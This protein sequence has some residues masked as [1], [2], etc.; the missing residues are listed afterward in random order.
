MGK[1]SSMC[2]ALEHEP[3]LQTLVD[4]LSSVLGADA[5]YK[6]AARDFLEYEQEKIRDYKEVLEKLRQ[7]IPTISP[8]ANLLE[9]SHPQTPDEIKV[10]TQQHFK[11]EVGLSKKEIS[12][13]QRSGIINRTKKANGK[14]GTSFYV[15]F[16]AIRP[17]VFTWEIQDAKRIQ[18]KEGITNQINK[19][20]GNEA[21]FRKNLK[22]AQSQSAKIK[23]ETLFTHVDRF[24][25]RIIQALRRN[26][27]IKGDYV[28]RAES[29][30]LG[31]GRV[32][33]SIQEL[34][35]LYLIHR[36]PLIE[37]LHYVFLKDGVIVGTNASTAG[38]VNATGAFDLDLFEKNYKSL[39][40]DAVYILHNHPSG[41][42]LPSKADIDM[43]AEIT[44]LSEGINFKGQLII[45]TDKFTFIP[46]NP[47]VD[48]K[49]YQELDYL[50]QPKRL[51][52]TR[53]SLGGTF[54]QVTESLKQVG[55]LLLKNENI[56][57]VIYISTYG[58]IVG[59]DSFTDEDVD[60]IDFTKRMREIGAYNY[61][62]FSPSKESSYK[63]EK[64][65]T[66]YSE[67]AAFYMDSGNLRATPGFEYNI[68]ETEKTLEPNQMRMWEGL[69]EGRGE[70]ENTQDSEPMYYR[71][72]TEELSLENS[73][74]NRALEILTKLAAQVGVE[75]VP[76]TEAEATEL[77]KNT[78][79]PYNGEPAFF[80]AGQV[81]YIPSKLTTKIALHEFSHPL[82]RSISVDNHNLFDKLFTDLLSTPEGVE[83]V[84]SVRQR[85]PELEEGSDRFKEEV[86]VHAL[87]TATQR[88]L[89]SLAEPKGFAKVI[90]DILV[91]F[92]QLLRKIFKVDVSKLGLQT[93]LDNLAEMLAKGDSFKINTEAVSASDVAAFI[94]SETENLA[95]LSKINN[96]D[97]Q[98]LLDTMF[99]TVSRE[100]NFIE[101]GTTAEKIDYLINKYKAGGLQV[102]KKQLTPYTTGVDAQVN[103][104]AIEQAKQ[105][106]SALLNS[107]NT[108]QNTTGK[109]HEHLKV[110]AKDFN[111]NRD[112]IQRFEFYRKNLKYWED[113]IGDAKKALAKNQ[114]DRNSGIYEMITKI[115]NSIENSK[116]IMKPL[117]AAAVSNTLYKYLKP[118]LDL[119]EEDYQAEIKLL[120][121]QLAK[122][123]SDRGRKTGQ[124]KIDRVTRDYN[125]GKV[126][127]E[128]FEQALRGTLVDEHG[129]LVDVNWFNSMFE[130]AGYNTDPVFAG[131]NL[132]VENNVA[133][134][135]HS[136]QKQSN[137]FGNLIFPMW[138]KVGFNKLKSHEIGERMGQK[139]K[140]L[141]QD[142][143]ETEVWEFK[144]EF[145]GHQ[146]VRDTYLDKIH[147]AKEKFAQ[148]GTDEDKKALGDIQEEWAQHRNDFWNTKYTDEF[149]E[150]KGML[151]KDSVGKEAARRQNE[152]YNKLTLLQDTVVDIED[153]ENKMLQVNSLFR[154]IRRLS[155]LR[156]DGG[157]KKTGE[158]LAVAERMKAFRE[159]DKDLY[160]LEEIGGAFQSAYSAYEQRLVASG[161]SP[162]S[163]SYK[164]LLQKW[165]DRNLRDVVKPDFYK[166]LQEIY[167]K[168][169]GIQAHIPN[170]ILAKMNVK[171]LEEEKTLLLR[172]HRDQDGHPIGSEMT[173]EKIAKVKELTEQIEAA[174]WELLQ[175]NGLSKAE[176]KELQDIFDV[177]MEGEPT[178]QMRLRMQELMDR[179]NTLGLDKI[180][181][182]ALFNLYAQLNDLQKKMP[183]DYY[184]D[185]VNSWL[186]TMDMERVRGQ[187]SSPSITRESAYTILNNTVLAELFEQSKEFE[188]WFR[189]NHIKTMG[190]NKETLKDE[191]KWER[192]AVWNVTRPIEEKY[193]ESTTITNQNG[194]KQIVRGQ[195]TLAYF[196]RMVKDGKGLDGK[197][198]NADG[199]P[200]KNYY[201]E[202]I[203][204]KTVDNKGRWLPKRGI[205]DGA[206]DDRYLN[207]E[208]LRMK[209]EN[210]DFFKALEATKTFH[211]EYQENMDSDG[212]IYL[213]FPRIEKQF[214][215]AAQSG[216]LM[217]R[218]IQQG[219]DF[220][221]NV[222]NGWDTG[223]NYKNNAQ[224]ATLDIFDD[225]MSGVP[226]TGKANLEIE[227]VSTDIGLTMMRYMTSGMIQKQKI[228]M[229]PIAK[230]LQAVVNDEENA[231]IVEK[232]IKNRTLRFLD[233]KKDVYLRAKTI[234][235]YI[236]RT[237]EGQIN[238][239]WGSESVI[240]QNLSKLVFAQ[241]STVYMALNFPSDV[242]NLLSAKFQGMV[243]AVAGRY[244]NV[245]S[246]LEAEGWASR[247]AMQVMTESYTAGSRSLDSQIME[248]F[249]PEGRTERHLGESATRSAGKDAITFKW[250]TGFRKLSQL[251]ATL[252][253]FGGMMKFKKV[254]QNGKMIPYLEAWEI[255]DGHIQ[256]KEG[257]DKEWG[258]DGEKFKA[259]RN[260]TQNVIDNLNGAMRKSQSPE[261]Q[262]YLAYRALMFLRRWLPSL[263]T[264]RFAYS[265]SLLN[266]SRGR[267]N[268]LLGEQKEGFYITTAKF[269][270]KTFT[271][272]GKNWN[273][274]TPKEKAAGLR[275]T[276]EVGQLLLIS[277]LMSLMGWDS[278]D[279]D[280]YKKL[281]AKSGALPFFGLTH[282]DPNNPFNLGGFIEQH[283]L[284]MLM[285]VAGENSQMAPYTTIGLNQYIEYASSPSS[286]A[287]GPNLK[288]FGK[289]A[290]DLKYIATG[291]NKQ[292]YQKSAGA[293]IWEEEG[294]GKIWK[295]LLTATGF[296]GS[297]INPGKTAQ[298]L[299]TNQQRTK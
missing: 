113:F 59:H 199:S 115:S 104:D 169:D 171:K 65:K 268:Y 20:Y 77:L 298:T 198:L 13:K 11:K 187:L 137:D 16:K 280:K 240:A 249:D 133:A 30:E 281:R 180:S 86:L 50:S 74:Q 5:G 217:Q 183:T 197:G 135:I 259:F 120:K 166:K 210:T 155:D 63:T 192:V 127:P 4:N 221:H 148:T 241:A 27:T 111:T 239:G 168:I 3:A 162:D 195:P 69:I 279:E 238:K 84:D 33:N 49:N 256:L 23:W 10:L 237:F 39:G 122:E 93:T 76:I 185:T 97:L 184:V 12:D 157:H 6:E 163:D 106:A 235:N 250:G 83:V 201:T 172:G 167:A 105:Q 21:N 141:D 170:T 208:Y 134:I 117:A 35:D 52:K 164:E 287:F 144:N 67:R 202:K 54:K 274:M 138:N 38:L 220:F 26:T 143:K 18:G 186:S 190:R 79:A 278:D 87:T 272:L 286:L 196:K 72:E 231:P 226:I 116:D 81:R 297:A 291:D 90:K 203:V 7:E 295:H 245:P 57:S 251:Q 68:L 254:E 212:R 17:D 276:A 227:K 42:H 60:T 267:N 109:I 91:A 108:L 131:L 211:L 146:I 14:L 58:D 275:F 248:L 44:R 156:D 189:A 264:N 246:F 283:S 263:L 71:P 299:V 130:G 75:A 193:Y 285:Q 177:L 121:A 40:A 100:I 142:G 1:Y 98:G 209:A 41:N 22:K 178:P 96:K 173:A 229:L 32:V 269:L 24:N 223:F 89:Q 136:L 261:G 45:D 128:K 219:K 243:E 234:N 88:Q 78:G 188:T 236:E 34:A 277:M 110:I 46:S 145:T 252:Q 255:K 270:S 151:S 230:A 82:L 273:Y 139:E 293:Y 289:V 266:S 29:G 228:A 103:L 94:K 102:I 28:S 247:V 126:T 218:T 112:S 31:N 176:G 129:K 296:T 204:G 101:K 51:N 37:K 73:E 292:Y 214:V 154:Q 99:E 70:V 215:E 191:E 107:L 181:K 80:Q 55:D 282:E 265:G 66:H 2:E 200:M 258:V 43:T 158:E 194:E 114:V 271:S 140:R 85:Y 160:F 253:T 206:L 118:Q 242:K 222:K 153:E 124:E 174:R 119:M 260:K 9:G 165:L 175:A 25:E 225:Q 150:V 15:K 61:A 159:A 53:I 205:A 19:A 149:R 123:S 47:I 8:Y 257:I 284:L 244:M 216:N 288:V 294:R 36:S 48:Y 224:L 207:Q 56:N 233:K 147:K 132:Y 92:R 152:L 179:K 95:D 62:V 262:R 161:K 182:E 213:D 290:I 125:N 64:N 232:S